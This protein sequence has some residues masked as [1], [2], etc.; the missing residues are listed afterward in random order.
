[1]LKNVSSHAVD[2][3]IDVLDRED[4]EAEELLVNWPREFW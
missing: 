3:A 2:G 4:R 1:M